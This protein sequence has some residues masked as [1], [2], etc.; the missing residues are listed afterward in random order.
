M[1]RR[2]VVSPV[3]RDAPPVIPRGIMVWRGKATGSWW[4]LVPSRNG[5]RLI[6]APTRDALAFAVDRHLSSASRPA[7]PPALTR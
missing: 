4:A 1:N 7:V 3:G 6:E 5:P 2:A